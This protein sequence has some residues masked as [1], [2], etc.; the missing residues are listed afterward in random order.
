MSQTEPQPAAP[1][2][3]RPGSQYS[4]QTLLLLFVVLGS[5]LAVFG[6][7]GIV[8]FAL[9][10]GLAIYLHRVESLWSLT[11]LALVVLCLMCLLTCLLLPA[12]QSAGRV[13]RRAVCQNNL[14][15]IALALL[16]YHQTNGCF[17][18]AYLADKNGKPMHSWRVLILP[19]MEMKALYD[20]YDFTEPW[21]GP[22]NK[23]LSATWLQGYVCPSETNAYGP[24]AA[25][26][27]YVAVVGRNAAWAGT[28]SRK[29]GPV[30][31]PGGASNTIM[32]VEVAN[33]GIP[34]MEPRDLSLDALAAAGA[35]SPAL[36]VSSN[37]GQS[38]DFFFTYDPCCGAHVA[39]ADGSVHYLPPGS[40]STE[41]LR[42]ILQV[43]GYRGEENRPGDVPYD[44]GRR[45][46]W[47]NIAALAVWLLS[48][49]ALLYR[50]VRSRK[51]K[52]P[53][54]AAG[55]ST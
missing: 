43:G 17:P 47:P 44:A 3:N 53:P 42:K 52:L 38:E 2:P 46:N 54:A 11:E 5:S 9:T 49:G 25:R 36:T 7:W 14:K 51:A 39:M 33:S 12:V 4:L 19:Y 16:Y 6:A 21:D 55:N 13:A 31:F 28:K 20:T 1:E 45:L 37:H 10:V 26:T 24:G 30:D 8:V 27:S 48:V 34:W 22:K 18:P 29:L 23:K 35:K 15:Q 32:V 40:L 41:N 50:A